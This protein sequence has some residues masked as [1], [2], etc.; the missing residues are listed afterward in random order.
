MRIYKIFTDY[1]KE[2]KWLNEMANEGYEVVSAGCGYKFKN[3]TPED[4]VY[5]A[6][7][8]E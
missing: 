2:E 7:G 3:I 6:L 4:A 5:K 8:I 1:A